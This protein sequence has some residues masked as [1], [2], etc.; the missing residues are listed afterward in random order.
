MT[1]LLNCPDRRAP[2]PRGAPVLALS[3]TTITEG[4]SGMGRERQNSPAWFKW[5]AEAW[6]TS[7]LRKRLTV[8]QR[9]I[10]RELW[11]FLMSCPDP[12]RGVDASGTPYTISEIASEIGV[13][14]D[15]LMKVLMILTEFGQIADIRRTKVVSF[16]RQVSDKSLPDHWKY[17]RLHSKP[18]DF[19]HFRD[20]PSQSQSQNTTANNNTRARDDGDQMDAETERLACEFFGAGRWES[21]H[22]MTCIQTLISDTSA[23][24]VKESFRIAIERNPPRRSF[25]YVRNIALD[26]A[27]RIHFERHHGTGGNGSRHDGTL[28]DEDVEGDDAN[29]PDVLPSETVNKKSDWEDMQEQAKEVF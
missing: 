20:A 10:Y 11:D 19:N 8:S 23:D 16:V 29:L 9:G 14:R 28:T 15:R 24:V 21:S 26:G 2:A 6:R 25:Q 4:E 17:K 12:G 27:E 13:R 3:K 18:S 5:W 1:L 22:I 7:S